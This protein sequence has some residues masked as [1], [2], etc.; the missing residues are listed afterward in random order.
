M[1]YINLGSPVLA[2]TGDHT[3]LL[4]IGYETNSVTYYDPVSGQ[5]V[6]L[7]MKEAEALFSRYNNAF[8]SY[9]R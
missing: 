6:K 3:G 1:Y 5:N 2:V 8:L 4:V 7:P 9:L